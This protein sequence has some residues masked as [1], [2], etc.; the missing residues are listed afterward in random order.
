STAE[1]IE[2]ARRALSLDGE[3]PLTILILDEAQQYIGNSTDRAVTFTEV[4]EAVQTQMDSRVMLVASGQSALTGT[5]L[6]QKLLHRFRI[7]VQLSD[8]DVEAVTRKVLLQK[9]PSGVEPVRT[10]L[11]RNAGEISKH[12]QGTRLAER[13]EDR[14]IIVEDYPLLPT[15]RRFWEECF[16]AVDAAGTHSQL[17]SQLRILDDALKS[18]AEGDLGKV[19]PADTLFE[20]IAPDLV[21][22]GVLLNEID[23]KIRSLDDGSEEGR[24]KKRLCGLVFL[25]NKLPRESGVDIGVRSTATI[26]ADLLIE[27]LGADSGPFRKRVETALESLVA[28]GTL[29]KVGEE[30]RL[31]TTEGAEWDR[32]FRERVAALQQR[33]QEVH[34]R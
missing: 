6:L 21:S 28:D 19:I 10:V 20:A 4:V 11:D 9:Q 2:A 13:V 22:T 3:L 33:Q 23:T 34:S 12:L 16:R 18:I 17:R 8:A 32:A 25:I 26:L 1:F 31:Q 27:D 29:T 7:N 24:L 14:Q 5:Q 15:R 30:Y